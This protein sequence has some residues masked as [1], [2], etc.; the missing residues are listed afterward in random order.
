MANPFVHGK[1]VLNK[2]FS[3]RIPARPSDFTA[4]QSN[5]SK[6]GEHAW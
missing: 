1:T 4:L 3:R 6:N 2:W 5:H